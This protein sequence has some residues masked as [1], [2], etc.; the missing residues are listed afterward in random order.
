[1]L[2][3]TLTAN[4]QNQYTQFQVQIEALQEH[5]RIIQSQL[6]RVGSVES[7][8]ESAALLLQEAIAEI[9]DVCPEELTSYQETINSLFGSTVAGIL[10]EATLDP[11]P[12]PQLEPTP[13]A[14]TDETITVESKEVT[15]TPI[16]TNGNGYHPLNLEQIK[17]IDWGTLRKIAGDRN[18]TDPNSRRL[19]RKF[20]EGAIAGQ[21]T[22]KDVEGLPEDVLQA[23][24]EVPEFS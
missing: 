14:P 3:A 6:Q 24:R 22:F 23:M 5:Q 1:M 10:P 11:E 7:K 13:D 19:T 2:L 15:D 21:I 4:L 16:E 9:S 17:L 20:V 18:I 8:M 12:E